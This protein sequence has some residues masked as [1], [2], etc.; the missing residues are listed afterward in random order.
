MIDEKKLKPFRPIGKRPV[1]WIDRIINFIF[2]ALIGSAMG[3]YI[4]IRLGI[5]AWLQPYGYSGAALL[6]GLIFGFLALLLG[7]RFLKTIGSLFRS[8][9]RPDRNPFCL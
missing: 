5:P 9:F 4:S 8:L 1:D 6:S 3:F 2:G 7:E